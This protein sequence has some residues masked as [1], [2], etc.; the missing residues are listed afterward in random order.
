MRLVCTSAA[1][2]VILSFDELRDGPCCLENFPFLPREAVGEPLRDACIFSLGNVCSMC[3]LV[4]ETSCCSSALV[5]G[6]EQGEDLTTW[7][8]KRGKKLLFN[9]DYRRCLR[10]ACRIIQSS[11]TGFWWDLLL[12]EV[13]VEAAVATVQQNHSWLMT[14]YSL[15]LLKH[16]Y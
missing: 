2:C 1:C 4:I 14:R 12:H 16:F 6:L 9:L 5:W 8:I 10:V 3:H 13:W 7:D 15:A 11:V